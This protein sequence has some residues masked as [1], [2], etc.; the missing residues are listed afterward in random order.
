MIPGLRV[1][2]ESAVRLLASSL[3][4]PRN[5]GVNVTLVIA[6]GVKWMASIRQQ[7]GCVLS[8]IMVLLKGLFGVGYG[9]VAITGCD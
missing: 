2:E 4:I 3:F 5:Y 6:T 8:M 7:I 9:L 1:A